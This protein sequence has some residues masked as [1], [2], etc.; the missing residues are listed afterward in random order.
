[1]A[2]SVDRAAWALL[3]RWGTVA[4]RLLA[5]ESLAPAWRELLPVYRRLEARGEIR[6]GRFVD[7]LTGEQF[8]LPEAVGRLRSVRRERPTGSLF[9]ISAADP[10]NL[11][12]IVTPGER[13]AA[14]AAN[15]ILLRDG[16]PLAIH[17]AGQ[18]RL[19]AELDP[20]GQWEL[21]NALLRRRVPPQLRAW[22]GR[23]A[24]LAK[25]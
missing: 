17:E 11:V 5:R 21:R 4:R 1:V 10:L 9:S 15:R 13:V 12:G 18:T 3:R 24:S 16:R 23:T 7:G 19:L 6:G 20:A 8:A 22:L 25:P 14:V 2:G